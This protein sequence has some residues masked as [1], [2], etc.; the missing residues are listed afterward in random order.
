MEGIVPRKV[1]G[2]PDGKLW[3]GL[4]VNA[5]IDDQVPY[6]GEKCPMSSTPMTLVAIV[7]TRF[8]YRHLHYPSTR[9][10]V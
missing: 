5:S 10:N 4:G 6:E 9:R 3:A 7:K 1:P 8:Q 2:D